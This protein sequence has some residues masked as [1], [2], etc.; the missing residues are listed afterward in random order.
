MDFAG[1][2]EKTVDGSHST[3]HNARR[4]RR[5]GNLATRTRKHGFGYVAQLVRAHHS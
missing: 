1:F 3:S 2:I 5:Q 4:S